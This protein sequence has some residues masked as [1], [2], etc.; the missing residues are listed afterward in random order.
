MIK[1]LIKSLREHKKGSLITII[2]SASEVV[3]E[4]VI[5]LCMSGLIDYGIDT[6]V[7]AKV[8]TYGAALFIFAL[9]QLTTGIG[10]ARS[11]HRRKSR[12]RLCR[13]PQAGYVRQR[14]NLRVFEYR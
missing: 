9:L 12:R 3:F 7:M 6:G 11:A 2:L 13:E 4:I 8:W 1:T 5:P 14:A 10:A